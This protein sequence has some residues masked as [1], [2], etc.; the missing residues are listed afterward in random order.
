MHASDEAVAFLLT[1]GRA[2]H[3]YGTPAHRLEAALSTLAERLGIQAQFFALP[4]SLH[5]SFGEPPDTQAHLMRVDPGEVNLEKLARLDAIAEQAARGRLPIDRALEAV[6]RTVEQPPRWG[7]ALTTLC[8]GVAAGTAAIFFGGGWREMVVAFAIG[9]V[10]GLL[11]LVGARREAL[12][13]VLEP[14][15]AT[16][17]TLVSVLAAWA[18]PPVSV[19]IATLAGIIVLVPGLTLTVAINELAMRHLV[20]GSTRL[21]GAAMLFLEIGVGV[22]LGSQLARWLPAVRSAELAPLPHW[23]QA[24]AVLV[25]AL[26]FA[27]LFRAHPRDLGWILG[28]CSLAFWGARGGAAL[29][30]D[31]LGV[32]VGAFAVAVASNLFARTLNRPAA[33]TQVPGILML[34]PGSLGFRSLSSLIRADV[35]SGVETAFTAVMIAASLVAGLLVASAIVPPRKAL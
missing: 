5:A 32:A 2:L 34:V 10:T 25:S 6:Q 18:M 19:Y 26:A 4:T 20:A 28:A 23:A 24:F 3:R 31:Q 14:L 8:W 22:M 27:I 7:D 33:I 17:S 16:L 13:R 21:A 12:A 35:V 11:S 29:L 9:T 15:A 1:L 30:D